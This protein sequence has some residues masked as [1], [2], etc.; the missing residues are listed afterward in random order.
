MQK[1]FTDI[2]HQ[3]IICEF[4]AIKGVFAWDQGWLL[5]DASK[6]G[7]EYFDQLCWS[8]P[9]QKGI[10]H[11]IFNITFWPILPIFVC[12]WSNIIVECCFFENYLGGVTHLPM[13][14]YLKVLPHEEIFV[15]NCNLQQTK[16]NFCCYESKWI[17]PLR[18]IDIK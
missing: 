18:C 9:T 8:W 14:P 13:E 5:D 1:V 16:V 12:P 17:I 11:V 2:L 7:S 10:K 6:G 3:M 4:L 15:I